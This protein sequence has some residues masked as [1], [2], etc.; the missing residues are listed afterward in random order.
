MTRL[1]KLSRSD[2]FYGLQDDYE[3]PLKFRTISTAEWSGLE[4][5]LVKVDGNQPASQWRYASIYD[6]NIIWILL[7]LTIMDK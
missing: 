7:Q 6:A 4:A 3:Q 2:P 5:E 1:I